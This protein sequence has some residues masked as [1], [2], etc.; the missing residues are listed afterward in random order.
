MGDSVQQKCHDSD[1]II[2]P[3]LR[4]NSGLS[5]FCEIGLKESIGNHE[6]TVAQNLFYNIVVFVKYVYFH[7]LFLCLTLRIN[8]SQ[9]L[10][11]F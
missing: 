11:R 2:K 7:C 3:I 10:D 6:S 8:K 5:L 1:K 4:N 9:Y